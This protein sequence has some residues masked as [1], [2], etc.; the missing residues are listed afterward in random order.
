MNRE[1]NWDQYLELAKELKQTASNSAFTEARLRSAISRAYYAL[2]HT[3]RQHLEMTGK[4]TF[5]Q[6]GK[7]SHD[8]IINYYQNYHDG[9]Y[10]KIG[11]ALR[12]LFINRKKADYDSIIRDDLNSLTEASILKAEDL[13][14]R[15]SRI[16]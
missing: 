12:A 10:K 5:F 14:L 6:R 16:K 11:I 1:W 9:A 15:L 8:D 7:Y 4:V 2:F 13:K 3:A